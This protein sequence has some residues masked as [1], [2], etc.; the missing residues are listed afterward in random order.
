MSVVKTGSPRTPSV[1]R[2][3]YHKGYIIQTLRGDYIGALVRQGRNWQAF[4][5]TTEDRMPFL[6]GTLD[7]GTRELVKKY[8]R[9]AL[10]AKK[11]STNLYDYEVVVLNDKESV[12]KFSDMTKDEAEAAFRREVWTLMD[13]DYDTD[14]RVEMNAA[15]E[16]GPDDGEWVSV[17]K[18]TKYIVP[19]EG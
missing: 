2:W 6:F 18:F 11:V 15:T 13:N 7:H 16:P 8:D 4:Y 14:M 17:A 10:E 9:D 12:S 19:E 3:K 1:E 5:G